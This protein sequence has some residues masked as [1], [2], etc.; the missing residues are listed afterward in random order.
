MECWYSICN[1][2]LSSFF[3]LHVQ[4]Q[5]L[6]ASEYALRLTGLIETAFCREWAKSQSSQ[7]TLNDPQT[8]Y[9]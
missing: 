7:L 1:S 8:A 5:G 9:Q 3:Y 6:V 4:V 2:R